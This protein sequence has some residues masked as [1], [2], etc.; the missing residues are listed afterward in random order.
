VAGLLDFDYTASAIGAARRIIDDEKWAWV[1]EYAKIIGLTNHKNYFNSGVLVFN[2]ANFRALGTQADILAMA[3]ATLFDFPDQDLLNVLCEGKTYYFPMRW[4]SMLDS[5]VP[6][7]G[8]DDQEEFD[9]ARTAPAIIHLNND[10]PW[11]PWKENNS[12]ER[13]DLFWAYA[14]KTPFEAA[15]K[16][17]LAENEAFEAARDDVIVDRTAEECVFSTNNYREIEHIEKA[18][19][20]AALPFKTKKGSDADELAFNIYVP[21][22][23]VESALAI[24]SAD[25]DEGA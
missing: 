14:A 11:K 1:R 15:L 10:K 9:E 3:A 18:L 6:G 21:T 23:T 17:M 12:R 2:T 5:D 8:I 22:P 4:N 20:A 19:A 25:T 7:L 24:L 13:T 16:A